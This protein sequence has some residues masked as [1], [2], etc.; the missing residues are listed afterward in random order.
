MT[1]VLVTCDHDA[2]SAS[3]FAVIQLL[4][5]EGTDYSFLVSPETP[6]FSLTEVREAVAG[7]LG[8]LP[9]DVLVEEV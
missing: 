9:D 5:E 3:A 1:T 8:L 7:K 6:F 4:S 2:F